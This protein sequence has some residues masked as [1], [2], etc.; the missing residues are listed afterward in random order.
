MMLG[1]A[2]A[3][4]WE[5][6]DSAKSFCVPSVVKNIL[7]S[8]WIIWETSTKLTKCAGTILTFIDAQDVGLFTK[9]GAELKEKAKLERI[10]GGCMG[11]NKMFASC[12]SGIKVEDGVGFE[13]DIKDGSY[14]FSDKDFYCRMSLR[15]WLK[16]CKKIGLTPAK[17]NLQVSLET[18]RFNKKI[19]LDWEKRLQE[20][21]QRNK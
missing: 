14:E 20:A 11:A 18:F 13:T 2:G 17:M 8:K 6:L 21:K 1:S 10:W 16:Y 5:W 3:I 7:K 4:Q 15:N 9:S 19:D 12:H